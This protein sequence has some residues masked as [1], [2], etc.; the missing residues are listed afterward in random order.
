[1]VTFE[2][3]EKITL[4]FPEITIEPH[5]EKISFRIKKKIFATYDEK[6]NRVT[7][8]LSEIDQDNFSSLSSSIYPVNNKW[9]KQGWT[10]IELS[11]VNPELL[12]KVLTAG[13]C[14]VAPKKLSAL[15]K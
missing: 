9:G 14:E 15:I 13:Y 3:F 6:H 2:T 7:V 11:Q 8:K 4:N 1:M 5:F 10:F 12:S